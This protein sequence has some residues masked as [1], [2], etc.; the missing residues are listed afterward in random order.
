MSENG[1]FIPLETVYLS[2]E[3]R[4]NFVI[5]KY[6][7]LKFASSNKFDRTEAPHRGLLYVLLFQ[8]PLGH[9]K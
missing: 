5:R 3:E 7:K 8:D 4:R 6:I 1:D 2:F 9:T